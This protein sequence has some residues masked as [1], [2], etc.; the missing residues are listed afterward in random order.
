MKASIASFSLSCL[1]VAPL[2]QAQDGPRGFGPPT[3][4]PTTRPNIARPRAADPAARRLA[5]GA[6]DKTDGKVLP[7][8]STLPAPTPLDQIKPQTIVLPSDAIEPWLLTKDA[9]PFMVIARTFRGDQAERG[10]LALAME[11]R[12]DYGLPAYILRT[13]DFPNHSNIRNVPPLAPNYQR[14]ANLAHP[15]RVRTYDEAAVLVGNEKTLEGSEA[16]LHRVKKIKPKCLAEMPSFFDW[17]TGLSTATRTTNP[18]VPTQNIL[19]GRGQRN[20]L[21]QK[22]NAGPRSVYRCPGRYTLK[23][24]DFGG[25]SVFNPTEKDPRLFD[26]GWLAKSPLVT[27]AED[28]ERLAAAMA[29]DAEVQRTGYQPY[30]YH[31]LTSSQVMI[32]S[33]NSPSDPAAVQ[34]RDSLLRIAGKLSIRQRAGILIAPGNTLTDLEDPNQPIKV[35]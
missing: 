10:A 16:L 31:D 11:L 1:L 26:K 18:F 34:L 13:K 24:A 32:G 35:R 8:A 12:R 9:G 14:K 5:T 2:A 4:A 20:K 7:A 33:F 29:K 17:R 25:R 28:A 22:M 27:A 30:V 15:E 19:P 3:A 21:I 6:A 23:V